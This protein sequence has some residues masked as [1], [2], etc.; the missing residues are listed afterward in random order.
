M[1]H[2]RW[3]PWIADGV[4]EGPYRTVFHDRVGSTND[5]A[6]ALLRA[7]DPGGVFVVAASQTGGRGRHGRAWASPPG[8]LYASIGLVDPAPWSSA[9]Q[10]GFVAGVALA[11]ALSALCGDRAR[12]SLKWPNDVLLG[13]AKL[14]GILLECVT[15][16]GDRLGCVAGFGVNC[17]FHPEGLPYPATSLA[18]AGFHQAPTAVLAALSDAFAATLARW[19]GGAGFA[20]TRTDWLGFAAGLGEAILVKTPAGTVDGRFAGLG[21][22]GHLLVDTTRGRVTIDAGDVF[23]PGLVAGAMHPTTKS[24]V[25]NEDLEGT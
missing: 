23:L 9:P 2:W 10:L 8:N 13:G 3:T 24:H 25:G 16:P 14:A 12:L 11:T 20:T 4:S 22:L 17:A 18:K 15:L 6:V 7:G 21:P 1:F 5:E 19:Q